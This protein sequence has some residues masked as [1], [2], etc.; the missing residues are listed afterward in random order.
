[1]ALAYLQIIKTVAP[2]IAQ[3]AA[4][5][6]PAF[7]SKKDVLK[8]DP[9]LAALIE[10]LQGAATQNAQSIHLLAQKMQQAIEGFEQASQSAQ[11][12][13]D[14]YK[15]LLWMALALSGVSLAVCLL[16]LLRQGA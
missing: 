14:L 9:A 10:E 6:L 12:Q 7:T 5:A 1:M 15:T 13:L 3:V 16:V 4:A 2:Y 11:K 8:S